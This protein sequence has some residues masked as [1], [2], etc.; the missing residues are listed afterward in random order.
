MK[1]EKILKIMFHKLEEIGITNLYTQEILS[2]IGISEK[3]FM[4]LF[5]DG[6]NE[7]IMD[8]LEYAG[9]LWLNDL[10]HKVNITEE[11]KDKF[12]VIMSN[13]ILGAEKY[14]NNLSLYIDLWKMI[15]DEN[16]YYLRQR[17]CKI[18]EL[19]VNEFT[20][21]LMELEIHSLTREEIYGLAIIVTALSDA[22]N[23]QY[24]INDYRVDFTL[25]QK[26]ITKFTLMIMSS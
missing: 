13:Y 11:K 25:F 7:L 14:T 4:L 10:K 8:S 3:Q 1:K 23:I 20:S 9:I 18:Y 15:K 19:Y 16:N 5:P 6:R 21:L 22:I 17:L 26:I 24:I 2:M 12:I